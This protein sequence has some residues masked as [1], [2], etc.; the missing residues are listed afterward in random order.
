MSSLLFKQLNEG[1]NAEPNAPEPEVAVCESQVQL[2]FYLNPYM[3]VAKVGEVGCLIFNDCARWRLG[4]TNDHGWYLGQCRYSDCAPAWGEFYEIIGKDD[5]RMRPV[6]WQTPESPGAG[7][8]HF[9][10]YLR[11]E[12]FE[13][14]AADWKF[15]RD[16]SAA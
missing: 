2:K 15:E 10:F 14:I 5:L 3:Y 11:D 13:C 4:Y 12:T 9:L 1:W 16:A 8:R 7:E 6:D